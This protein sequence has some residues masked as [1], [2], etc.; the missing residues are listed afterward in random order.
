MTQRKNLALARRELAKYSPHQP[1]GLALRNI[2]L[3]ATMPMARM[4]HLVKLLGAAA[5]SLPPTGAQPVAAGIHSHRN[6]PFVPGLRALARA[7]EAKRLKEN[8][9]RH[10]LGLVRVGQH[11][12]AQPQHARLVLRV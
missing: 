3:G 9:L 6:Q 8:L 11:Q 5:P 1:L 2:V 7:K 4:F 12:T 10:L